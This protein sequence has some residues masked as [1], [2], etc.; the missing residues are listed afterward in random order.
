MGA[1]SGLLYR[2]VLCCLAWGREQIAELSTKTD[3][4]GNFR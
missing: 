1:K 3:V 2:V 4:T